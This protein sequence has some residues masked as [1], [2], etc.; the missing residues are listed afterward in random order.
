MP[1]FNMH[2]AKSQLSRL[3]EAAQRGEDITIAKAGKPVAKLVPITTARPK[4]VFGVLKGL[5]PPIGPEFDEPL[6]DDILAAFNG[7]GE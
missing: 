2:Q 3:V 5:F 4:Y 6:P 1:I 7:E